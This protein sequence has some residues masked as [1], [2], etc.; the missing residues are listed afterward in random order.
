MTETIKPKLTVAQVT[1]KEA[2]TWCPGCVLPNTIIHKNPSTDQIENVKIGDKVLGL[3]GEYHEVYEV[4]KHKHEGQMFVIKSKCFG[5]SVTTPEHPVLIVKREKF[6]YHNKTFLQ[7]WVEAEKIRN[8]DYL[9]YPIL[10]TVKDL[11]EVELKL[12]KKIMDR[13]SKSLPKSVKI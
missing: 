10:K 1:T 2:P 9:V 12:T 13:K 4:L 5:E 7:E 8:G 3:D 6:G 11:E